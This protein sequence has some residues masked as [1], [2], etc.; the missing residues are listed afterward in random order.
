MA[1]YVSGWSSWFVSPKSWWVAASMKPLQKLQL[2]TWCLSDLS[3]Q[4]GSRM[5]KDAQGIVWVGFR[6]WQSTFFSDALI[7]LINLA[8][9]ITLCKQCLGDYTHQNKIFIPFL[10]QI[11]SQHFLHFLLYCHCHQRA[12]LGSGSSESVLIADFIMRA[13]WSVRQG[14]LG[15]CKASPSANIPTKMA[16]LNTW[17]VVDL[18]LR[19]MMEFVNG[20]DD[21]P[22]MKWK[23]IQ[24]FETTN[25]IY[26]Y[27]YIHCICIVTQT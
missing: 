3:H 24:T 20:K 22:Y 13:N 15:A 5:L 17:L 1:A 23:M 8:A 12:D 21:I 26:I 10:I 9:W 11:G 14:S 4:S 25:Q 6:T 16:S 27:I 7:S 18:P 2:A 19:K